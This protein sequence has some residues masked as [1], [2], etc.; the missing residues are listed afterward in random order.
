MLFR[1]L[2]LCALLVGV[3]TGLFDSAVQRWQVVPLILAAEVF[4]VAGEPQAAQHEHAAGAAAH[5]HEAQAW[6]PE[7]GFE[8]T[9]YTVLANVLNAIG[10]AL[11]LL[12][13]MAFVNRQR[14]G[15]ALSLKNDYGQTIR[16]GLLWG[17][18]AWVCL[19]AM[20]AIGLPP[21]LPGMQAA[22]LQVRQL[23]WT[24]TV[25]CGAG[26]LAM[27]CLVRAKWRVLGLALLVLPYA[28]GAPHHE[29]SAFAGMGAE[30]MAQMQV[31]ASQFVV[32]TSIAS[33]VQW[34]LLGTLCAVA[35][36]RWLAPVIHPADPVSSTTTA[37]NVT[38]GSPR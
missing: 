19:F 15:Y 22:P 37:A 20:P 30:A 6:E 38:A 27:L 9:A 14:G 34:L 11:L 7:A 36:A 21:E 26:G 32:A 10:S 8:R 1:R 33:A 2:F 5:S 29:G 23:W 13:L 24:L 12:P 28:V 17:T 35:A 4:E 3:L 16:H 18:A 31:L 25:A